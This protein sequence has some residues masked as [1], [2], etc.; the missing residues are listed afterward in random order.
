MDDD[1]NKNSKPTRMPRK[2]RG[3]PRL[4]FDIFEEDWWFVI[5]YLY[6]ELT[7]PESFIKY[8]KKELRTIKELS[9]E[10]KKYL[11]NHFD[12]APDPPEDTFNNKDSE[13]F[14]WEA[15]LAYYALC[16]KAGKYITPDTIA[17]MTGYSYE[18][19]KSKF[20]AAK[21]RISDYNYGM[22]KKQIQSDMK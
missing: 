15:W 10:D 14:D 6:P 20:K 19:V 3:E 22:I 2:K 18:T 17:K 13:Y 21:K 11:I 16:Q 7:K 12:K 8:L 1:N 5:K 9:P 4:D